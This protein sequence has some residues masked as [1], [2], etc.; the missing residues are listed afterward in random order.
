MKKKPSAKRARP[1]ASA[2]EV[3]PVALG[4]Y[5]LAADLEEAAN[6]CPK[7]L[8]LNLCARLAHGLAVA[9]KGE[10][11]KATERALGEAARALA[12]VTDS[13]PPMGLGRVDALPH[14]DRHEARVW[15][16]GKVSELALPAAQAG[17]YGNAALFAYTTALRVLP[18]KRDARKTA[19]PALE[20]W[21]ERYM[22]RSTPTAR[23]IAERALQACGLTREQAKDFF[24]KA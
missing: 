22:K 17:R 19:L 15:L 23:G 14:I 18:S 16:L 24:R 9:L 7:D 12:A 4:A 13:A 2:L 10:S 6:R 21:L 5:W 11:S 8:R 1:K 20:T 3:K